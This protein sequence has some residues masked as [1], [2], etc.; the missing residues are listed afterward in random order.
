LIGRSARSFKTIS[1]SD[2]QRLADIAMVDR[3]NFFSKHRK[4]AKAYKNRVLCSALC[5]GAALHF[6]DGRVGINDFDVYTFYAKNPRRRWCARALR[7]RDFG[8]PKFGKSIDRPNYKGRRVDLMGR[9][10][11]VG[12]GVNP[13]AA[14]RPVFAGWPN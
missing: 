9:S 8:H 7:S 10:I 13:V 4:W 14:L 12:R 2:L 5:Q 11:D 3:R 1:D 6:V